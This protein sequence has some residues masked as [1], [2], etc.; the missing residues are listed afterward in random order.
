[1]HAQVEYGPLGKSVELENYINEQTEQLYHVL[2]DSKD[3]TR[4][5]LHSEKSLESRGQ[6]LFSTHIHVVR[7]HEKNVFVRKDNIDFLKSIKEAFRA[8]KINLT[9]DKK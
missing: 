8:A 4:I 5:W 1:M 6:P 7:P 3:T 2:D 9:K